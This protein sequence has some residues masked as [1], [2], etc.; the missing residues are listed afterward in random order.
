MVKQFGIRKEAREAEAFLDI[1]FSN[2]W[3]LEIKLG[4][5]CETDADYNEL[6]GD[7]VVC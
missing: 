2:A 1:V 4:L 6:N 3:H 5:L 7:E